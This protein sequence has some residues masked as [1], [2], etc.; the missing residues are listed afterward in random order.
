MLS[1][2]Y[3][4]GRYPKLNITKG[5]TIFSAK[6]I[7]FKEIL[8]NVSFNIKEGE[9]LGITG[10]A[11][12]GRSL[13]ANCLFGAIKSDGEI[14]INGKLVEINSPIDAIKNHIALVPDLEH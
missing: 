7:G 13:L 2:H 8:N 12:S 3:I 6:N 4:Q 5:Q 1:I 10:L 11:G 9:I 14:Y